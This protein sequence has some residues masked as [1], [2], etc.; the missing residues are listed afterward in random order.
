MSKRVKRWISLLL[1]AAMSLSALQAAG[2]G[3]PANAEPGGDVEIQ[4]YGTPIVCGTNPTGAGNKSLEVIRDG[5]MPD[6]NGNAAQEYDTWG[7][8]PHEGDCYFGYTFGKTCQ[9]TALVYQDGLHFPDGG[10]FVGDTVRLQ[11]LREGEWQDAAGYTAEPAYPSSTASQDLGGSFNIYTY[12]FAEP[13]S[14]DGIRIAGTAAGHVSCAE[15]KVSATEA[16]KLD[17]DSNL[18]AYYT[19]ESAETLGRDVS[20]NGRNAELNGDFTVVPGKVENAAVFDGSSYLKL[21]DDLTVGAESYTISSWV[22]WENTGSWTTVSCFGREG[23]PSLF[24]LG[25]SD[26]NEPVAYITIDGLSDKRTMIGAGMT[27]GAGEW[28]HLATVV[29]AAHNKLLLYVDG[30]LKAASELKDAS[31]PK[32]LETGTNYI[33]KSYFSGDPLLSGKLDEFR[34]YDR[35]LAAGEIKTLME[36]TENPLTDEGLTNAKLLDRIKGGRLG[37]AAGVAWGAPTELLWNETVIPADQVPSMPTNFSNMF[38]QDDCYCEIPFMEAFLTN[39]PDCSTEKIGE[40]FRDFN[41]SLFHGNYTARANLRAGMKGAEAGHYLNNQHCE[42]QDWTI[43]SNFVGLMNPGLVNRAISE[44]WRIGHILGYGDGVYGGVWVSAMQAKAFTAESLDEVLEA[45]RQAIPEGTKFRN[46]LED[47]YANYEAGDTYEENYAKI[48]AK[49]NQVES[50]VDYMGHAAITCIANSASV[51]MGLLYGEGDLDQTIIISMR[52]GKDSDCTPSTAGSIL[53][54]YL[55]YAAIGQKYK[56]ALAVSEG[57]FGGT[58]WDYEDYVQN[59]FTLAKAVLENEGIAYDGVA[60]WEVPTDEAV[61]SAPFE[62]LPE[63]PLVKMRCTGMHKKEVD[64]LA[65]IHDLS[66]TGIESIVWDFGD[67]STGTGPAPTHTYDNY[68]IYTVSC[69]VTNKKD[70]SRTIQTEVRALEYML[71]YETILCSNTDPQ[72][73]G[74]KDI[75]VICDGDMPDSTAEYG[76]QYDTWSSTPTADG[77]IYFGYTYRNPRAFNALVYQEG[78]NNT[79]GGWFANGSMRVQVRI[80]GEWQDVAGMRIDPLYPNSDFVVDFGLPFQIYTIEFDEIVGDAIR[81]IG[82]GGG[83]WKMAS[84]A[85][86]LPIGPTDTTALEE[87]IAECEKLNEADYTAASWKLFQSIFTEAKRVAL[88]EHPEQDAVN[89]ARESL[90]EAKEQL[91]KPSAEAADPTALKALIA[92]CEGLEEEEYTESTW[93]ALKEALEA[94]K[95]YLEGEELTQKGLDEMKVQ[96]Q[97]AKNRLKKAEVKPPVAEKK[98]GWKYEND[99]WYLYKNDVK[100]TDWQKDGKS[101]YYLGT[102]G[103]MRTGWYAVDKTWYFSNS[104]GAMQTGWKK[105]GSKWYYFAGSGAM[106]TGWYT[107]GKS[108]Y[109]SN[110]SGVMQT[111]WV[112]SGGKWYY[113]A[114]SGAMRTGWYTVGKTWYYS[115]SSGVMQ[116][117]W[118]KLGGKWYYLAGSGAMRTSWYKVGKTWYY[119]NSSGVM[120]TGWVKSGGKWYYMDGSGKMLASASRR[121]GGRTYRFNASG[122]CLNP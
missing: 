58:D 56:N 13:V 64:F 67:G 65:S 95:L 105:L 63:L 12:T 93:Q 26:T 2:A 36:V 99:A 66:G 100:L 81:I 38:A 16:P 84:V 70:L 116:T 37:E 43:E 96:L 88:L 117:G 91:V 52:G 33:G 32:D 44:A 31:L 22:S 79:D 77:L 104:S 6:E 15:L 112:K 14:G 86:L 78:I 5:V 34:V 3:L 111:G 103:K 101:W 110:S 17:I 8:T 80:D 55:G 9:F 72:G 28:H 19:F 7:S 102:D 27:V 76:R 49:W 106:R 18:L 42:D 62:Q 47:V 50:C 114:G 108:W 74:N 69:T 39:G 59:T 92:E 71:D 82:E 4:A 60:G 46:M 21:P 41:A 40:S 97:T 11:I 30:V 89:A 107:V 73:M 120:Q 23:S 121:I 109:Y 85:E 115:N 20:G 48:Q 122:V 83:F 51:L 1:A 61:I 68:G 29:D 113:L 53:G 54:T 10:W 35:A 118:K 119:S 87:L 75:H 98:N 94:A 45:G 90:W 24:N 57:I 25:F